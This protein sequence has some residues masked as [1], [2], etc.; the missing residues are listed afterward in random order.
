MSPKSRFLALTLFA[1]TAMST[2]AAQSVGAPD[3]GD[4]TENVASTT[5]SL[6][7]RPNA[8]ANSAC[9]SCSTVGA[10]AQRPHL[11]VLGGV[12]ALGAGLA[13]R[14]RR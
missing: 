1:A 8:A 4:G 13:R 6:Q 5:Q 10:P 14:R 7:G 2:A 9:G 3:A 12:L 11:A